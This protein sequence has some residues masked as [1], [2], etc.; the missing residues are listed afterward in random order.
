VVLFVHN[1]SH[2]DDEPY[3]TLL[4]EKGFTGYPSLCFMDADGNVLVKQGE[5]SVEAF[6]TTRQ[7]LEVVRDLRA[8]LAKKA[9]AGT[10]RKLFL[11]ELELQ[12]LRADDIKARVQTVALEPEDRKRVDQFLVDAEVRDLRSR[13]RELGSDKV[14]EW[15]VTMARTG[16]RPTEATGGLFWQVVLGWSATNGDGPLAQT[17]FDE[18]GKLKLPATLKQRNEALLEQARRGSRRR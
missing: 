10:E 7:K 17:A 13:S 14:N 2:A 11:A 18:L 9:D 3:P 6:A 16:R 8:Q 5:R 12:M 1:T 4:R 15:I